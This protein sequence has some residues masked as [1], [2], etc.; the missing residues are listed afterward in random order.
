M[1]AQPW[2]VEIKVR[3]AERLVEIAFDSGER[4]AIPA[5]LLRVMTPSAE[6]RGHGPAVAEPKPIALDKADVGIAGV[7]PVGRYALR[8]TFDDGHD[9]GLYTWVALHRIGRDRVKLEAEHAALLAN[10]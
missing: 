10:R 3:S 5:A 9:S 7:T 6:A 8:I 1:N 2:P 4:F